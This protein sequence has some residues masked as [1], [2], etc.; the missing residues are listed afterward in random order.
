MESQTSATETALEEPQ[1]IQKRSPKRWVKPLA[2]TGIAIASFYSSVCAGLWFGQTR[3]IFSPEPEITT[4]PAKFNAK[5][6]DV[7]IPVTKPD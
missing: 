1:D 5:Y 3:L 7:L 2:I 6:E 4:T